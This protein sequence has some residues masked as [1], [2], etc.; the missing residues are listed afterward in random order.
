MCFFFTPHTVSF[1]GFVC[2]HL[3]HGGLGLGAIPRRLAAS[4]VPQHS[5]RQQSLEQ[6]GW[7]HCA[8]HCLQCRFQHSQVFRGQVCGHCGRHRVVRGPGHGGGVQGNK[9]LS[10]SCILHVFLANSAGT[11]AF[12]ACQN[13]RYSKSQLILSHF[14]SQSIEFSTPKKPERK[15]QEKDESC[16]SSF[17]WRQLVFFFQRT[18]NNEV[19]K[20]FHSITHNCV[21]DWLNLAT[22][23]KKEAKRGRKKDKTFLVFISSAPKIHLSDDDHVRKV[24]NHLP[25]CQ[26]LWEVWGVI[27][28]WWGKKAIS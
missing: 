2:M 26:C 16:Q 18:H 14:Q 11:L 17:C 23:Q 5:Q 21:P 20:A 12:V 15:K 24:W 6:S 25:N 27:A 10:I 8:G 4:W 13:Q 7:L 1:H 9:S 19:V 3:R 22:T 28:D